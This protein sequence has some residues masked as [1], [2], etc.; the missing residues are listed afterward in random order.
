MVLSIDF[1]KRMIFLQFGD[2]DDNVLIIRIYI[3]L[4]LIVSMW[5]YYYLFIRVSNIQSV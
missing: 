2:D 5:K 1:Y 4:E 3:V